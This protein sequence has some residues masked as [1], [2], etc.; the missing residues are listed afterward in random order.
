MKLAT[1]LG[2][3][4]VVPLVA[5]AAVVPGGGNMIPYLPVPH[6]AAVLLDTGSTNSAGYRI[7]IQRSGA[8]EYVSGQRRSTG[9]V[10]GGL[11]QRLFAHLATATQ[12]VSWHAPCMKSVSFGTAFFVYWDHHRSADLTCPT[13]AAWQSVYRDALAIASSLSLQQPGPVMRPLMPGEHRMPLPKAQP[14]PAAT[15]T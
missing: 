15:G 14:S 5:L 7:V 12:S 11:T 13:D 1:F 9:S 4:L 8:A 10:D 3:L 2:V 6:G